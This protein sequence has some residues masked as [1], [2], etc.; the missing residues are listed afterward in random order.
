M[1][2]DKDR[3]S[4][5]SDSMNAGAVEL[6]SR[7]H[8]VDRAESMKRGLLVIGRRLLAEREACV[9]ARRSMRPLSN[10]ERR[11]L[12]AALVEQQQPV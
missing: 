8:V 9:R 4:A 6:D 12:H 7:G 2:M 5:A 11:A 1:N 10:T 3:R